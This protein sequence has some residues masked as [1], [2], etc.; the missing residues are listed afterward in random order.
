MMPS[1]K[2]DKKILANHTVYNITLFTK[3]IILTINTNE[4]KIKYKV[5]NNNRELFFGMRIQS[6]QYTGLVAVD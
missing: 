2:K 4:K 5:C 3:I 6:W 1:A